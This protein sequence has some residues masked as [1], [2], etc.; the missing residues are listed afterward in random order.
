[1]V[2]VVAISAGLIGF[3]SW[4]AKNSTE[5]RSRAATSKEFIYKGWEFEGEKSATEGWTVTNLSAVRVSEGVLTATFSSNRNPTAVMTQQTVGTK[6]PKGAKSLRMRLAIAAPTKKQPQVSMSGTVTY[7]LAGK[8][9]S[10]PKPLTF[11]VSQTGELSDVIVPFPDI[12]EISIQSL[13]IAFS[14]YLPGSKLTIDWIRLVGVAPRPTPYPTKG[15]TPTPYPKETLKP[16]PT[17]FPSP[18]ST[19]GPKPT[20]KPTY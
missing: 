7:T 3:T 8:T 17:S 20:P 13:K 2:L 14:E 10:K 11:G 12:G 4:V 19:G 9:A 5:N 6:L 16:T 1:M 15:P 18:Y